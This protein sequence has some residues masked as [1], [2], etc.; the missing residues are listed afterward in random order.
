[1]DR[2]SAG[3][4]EIE[5]EKQG[6]AIPRPISDHG[7]IG[8][9]ATLA[10]VAKDGTIDFMCW[11]NFDS[12]TIFAALLDPENGGNFEISPNIADARVVHQGRTTSCT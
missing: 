5:R 7:V 10:L 11:P 1:M 8:D 12:P 9:L 6:N 4:D 2:L 3:Y